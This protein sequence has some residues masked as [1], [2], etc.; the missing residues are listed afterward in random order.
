HP[1][2]ATPIIVTLERATPRDEFDEEVM[3]DF[4]PAEAIDAN[5][6][7]VTRQIGFRLQTMPMDQ[8]AE[9]GYWLDTGVLRMRRR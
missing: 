1:A 3:E 6:E 4:S 7:D 8:Q 5:N 9:G 2:L